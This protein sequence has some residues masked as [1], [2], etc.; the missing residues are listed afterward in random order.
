MA[1]PFSRFALPALLLVVIAS[2]GIVVGFVV[3]SA[4]VPESLSPAL[5]ISNVPVVTQDY[6]DERKVAVLAT[7]SITPPLVATAS[8]VVTANSCTSNG[9]FVSTDSSFAVN[10]NPVLNLATE[11]PLWRDLKLGD[12]GVDVSQVQ[13]EFSR[14][15]YPV[16][17]DGIFDKTTLDAFRDAM[18]QSGHPT[19]LNAN[20]TRD[21][22]Q[23]IPSISTLVESCKLLLGHTINEGSEVAA[24]PSSLAEARVSETPADMVPGE[25]S[26]EIG[27]FRLDVDSD[28]SITGTQQLALLAPLAGQ[29]NMQNFDGDNENQAPKALRHRLRSSRAPMFSQ[30][31]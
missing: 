25:R 9:M 27:G 18:R 24:L 12:Q 23:W 21:S 7:T 2:C 17:V 16:T 4:P 3:A 28:G 5:P 14:I 11:T 20:F 26:L 8:G 15:G 22:I 1:P 13:E 31:L 19:Y 6:E 10:G 30:I 29:Q